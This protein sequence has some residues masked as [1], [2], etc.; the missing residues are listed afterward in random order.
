VRLAT[1]KS[2]AERNVDW[3][4]SA[5]YRYAIRAELIKALGDESP[6]VRLETA[7][8]VSKFDKT[9]ALDALK[10]ELKNAFHT[11]RL[12]ALSSIIQIQGEDKS[13]GELVYLFQSDTHSGVRKV[14]AEQLEKLGEPA[15]AALANAF[16]GKAKAII[17]RTLEA[18]QDAHFAE[19][20]HQKIYNGKLDAD[21]PSTQGSTMP[22]L[23]AEPK[24]IN[25]PPPNEQRPEFLAA[26]LAKPPKDAS[27]EDEAKDAAARIHAVKQQV[28]EKLAPALN[29]RICE[30]PHDTLEQKKELARWVN[31]QLEPLGLA[32]QE[33]KTGRPGKLRGARGNRP[34]GCFEIEVKI[35]GKQEYPTTSDDLPELQLM[36]ANPPEEVRSQY[37]ELVKKKLNR[38]FTAR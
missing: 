4:G 18:F 24:P 35:D 3:K 36:D 11:I 28:A 34:T 19:S 38:T 10:K 21:V 23:E 17:R 30:K 27:Y 31:E 7:R 2:L 29:A 15:L 25:E 9:M 20:L 5:D 22:L 13:I 12:H 14:A 6:A 16:R 37:R 1:V 33:P 8:H 32:V 26:L